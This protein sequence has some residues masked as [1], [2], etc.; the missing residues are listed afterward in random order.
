LAIPLV[1]I[2]GLGLLV[3]TSGVAIPRNDAVT[4]LGD[5][6]TVGDV[7]AL[8]S[9]LLA[10]IPVLSMFLWLGVYSR[11]LDQ[12]PPLVKTATAAGL[13][14]V[15]IQPMVAVAAGVMVGHVVPAWAA[16]TDPSTLAAIESDFLLVQWGFDGALAAFDV[17]LFVAQVAVAVV[18]LRARQRIWTVAGWLGILNGAGNLLGVFAFAAKPLQPFGAIGFFIGMGWIIATGI[19]LLSSPRP[20]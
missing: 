20:R 11:F 13:V 3:L 4:Y 5:V 17:F 10:A 18:M 12:N 6:S 15:A 14:A 1:A 19:G 8:A 9:W 16:A 2:P 7:L